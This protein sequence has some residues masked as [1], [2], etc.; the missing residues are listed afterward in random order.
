MHACSGLVVIAL[1]QPAVAALTEPLLQQ[2]TARRFCGRLLAFTT[3]V[4]TTCVLVPSAIYVSSYSYYHLVL[5]V[6]FMSIV[7]FLFILKEGLRGALEPS[8]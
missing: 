5:L 1:V 2:A 6:C 4:F 3:F 7:R 8:S